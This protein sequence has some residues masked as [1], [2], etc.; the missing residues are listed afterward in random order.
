M[1]LQQDRHCAQCGSGLNTP[2]RRVHSNGHLP[3]PCPRCRIDLS[4]VLL[5]EFAVDG[6]AQCSGLFLNQRTMVQLLKNRHRLQPIAAALDTTGGKANTHAVA[7]CP[8]CE[9]PMYQRRHHRKSRVVVDVC[10]NHGIWLDGSE[11]SEILQSKGKGGG[12]H[13]RTY[14]GRR[15]SG[16]DERG[17]RE[18]SKRGRST[19]VFGVFWLVLI[20]D[21][22]DLIKDLLDEMDIDF[23]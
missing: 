5:D 18:Y 7:G 15:T 19:G 11:L 17:R 16:S 23:D 14:R 1:A 20:D 6:C 10:D 21:L 9:Q 13:S 2:A 12:K 3:M 4:V 8:E 22:I